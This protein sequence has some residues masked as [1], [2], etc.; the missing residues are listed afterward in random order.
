VRELENV[1]FIINDGQHR[2]P[3]GASLKENSAPQ[4]RKNFSAPLRDGK[5][6]TT[7]TGN[8]IASVN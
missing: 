3:I 7:L 6:E 8:P 2:S 5:F 4:E 1:E